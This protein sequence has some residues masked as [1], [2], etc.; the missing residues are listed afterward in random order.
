MSNVDTGD[1]HTTTCTSAHARTQLAPNF[2]CDFCGTASTPE[3]RTGPR[4]KKTL[5]NRCG[6][7]WSQSRKEA[8]QTQPPAPEAGTQG[9]GAPA[10]ANIPAVAKDPASTGPRTLGRESP[11]SSSSSSSS[12]SQEAAALPRVQVHLYSQG[13]RPPPHAEAPWPHDPAADASQKR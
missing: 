11:S 9:V 1:A 10:A 6:I 3:A 5:C 12:S 8:Q 13:G 7:R 2:R 4:G